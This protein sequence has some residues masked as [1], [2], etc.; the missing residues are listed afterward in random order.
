MI[1]DS[2]YI[3]VKNMERA[4]EFYKQLFGKEPV[5]IDKRYTHFDLNGFSFGLYAP[6]VDGSKIKLGNNC[7]PDFRVEDINKEYERVKQFTPALV[8]DEIKNYGDIKLFQFKD[9]EG[10]I[11]EIYEKK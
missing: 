8:D 11:L 2:V 1:I 7:V 6:A 3:S 9:S 4:I 5:K 10:N